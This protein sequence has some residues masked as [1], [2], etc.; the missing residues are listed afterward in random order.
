MTTLLQSNVRPVGVFNCS[1]GGDDLDAVIA[2]LYA[3]L[4]FKEK[5]KLSS[6]NSINWGRVMMQ[7][8]HYFYGYLQVADYIGETV[9]ISVPSGAFGNLCAGGLARKMG[10]PIKN[11][12]VANNKN[13]CLHRIFS[14]GVFCKKPIYETL[15]SAID[16]LVPYNFWRYLYFC[17]DGDD[18]K[19][20]KWFDR[21]E[22]TG[23]LV[24]DETTLKAY[25][26]GFLS[27][28]ISDE[29]TS[30]IIRS[31]FE[32]ENYL[33]DPHGAVALAASDELKNQLGNDKLICLA[34]AHP[35]KFPTV[36]L[37][38]L[39]L[40]ELP[41]AAKHPSIEAAKTQCQ[42]GYTC[43]H[44]HLEEA[45]LHAMNYHWEHTKRA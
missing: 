14:E 40:K 30:N 5:V 43:D 32:T 13:A 24:F 28:S 22:T 1:E 36:I 7:T 39:N 8:V 10:L 38:A 4:S 44:A 3:N 34:T 45:L 18:H 9:N 12:V 31:V 35:S 20:K 23:E 41:K 37:K 29:Q 26:K 15:S 17:V 6:V 33:L 21:F 27:Y 42:K 2:R 16:I 11:L 25:S 19:I